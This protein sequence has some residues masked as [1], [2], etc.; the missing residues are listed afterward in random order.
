MLGDRARALVPELLENAHTVHATLA[1]QQ[2]NDETCRIS[3][4]GAVQNEEARRLSD[5]ALAQNEENHVVCSDPVRTEPGGGHDL[6]MNFNTMPELHWEFGYPV[7]TGQWG[8]GCGFSSG[9]SGW[10]QGRLT[11]REQPTA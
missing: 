4:A 5:A 1:T 11:L 7:A 9:G 8:W 2:Q 3:D 10:R 6:W